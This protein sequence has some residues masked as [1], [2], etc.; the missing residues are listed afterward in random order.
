M[1]YIIKILHK[2]SKLLL[3]LYNILLTNARGQVEFYTPDIPIIIYTW[4]R[5]YKTFSMLNST[6]HEISTAHKSKMPANNEVIILLSL[7]DVVF[8]MLI[9][10][11]MPTIV[12]ILAFMSRINF[13]LS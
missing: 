13:V 10:V 5:G 4:P 2:L 1:L 9:N 8:I 3:A 11:K 7:S 12:G 6:E